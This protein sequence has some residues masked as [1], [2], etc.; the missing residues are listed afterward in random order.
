VLLGRELI[1]TGWSQTSNFGIKS[2]FKWWNVR[3]C[4][5]TA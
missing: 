4:V 5:F 3:P 2:R 1:C